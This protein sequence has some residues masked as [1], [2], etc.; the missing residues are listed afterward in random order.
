MRISRRVFDRAHRT[1]KEDRDQAV[2]F[3]LGGGRGLR[4]V[5]SGLPPEKRKA[6][7]YGYLTILSIGYA[8]LIGGKF[9][10]SIAGRR[11]APA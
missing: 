2:W 4:G 1:A 5:G 7:L 6:V 9:T 8:L 10:F 11:S 3:A